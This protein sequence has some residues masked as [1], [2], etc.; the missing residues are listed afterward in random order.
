MPAVNAQRSLRAGHAAAAIVEAQPR[1]A[2]TR[3]IAL[4]AALGDEIATRPLFELAVRTGREC[5]FPRC[6]E[7]GGLDFAR[8]L[9]WGSLR[10]GDRGAELE[11]AVDWGESGWRGLLWR[12]SR[13]STAMSAGRGWLVIPS[14]FLIQRKSQRRR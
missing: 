6:L 7:G 1:F 4:F 12:R 9:D 5:I 14:S 8:V 11:I 3:R 10:V 13:T 2:V